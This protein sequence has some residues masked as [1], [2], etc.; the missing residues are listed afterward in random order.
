MLF[1]HKADR[2]N[3]FWGTRQVLMQWKKHVWSLV[4]HILPY[5]ILI[6]TENAAKH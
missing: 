2:S 1:E 3:I 5:S 6:R 4:L